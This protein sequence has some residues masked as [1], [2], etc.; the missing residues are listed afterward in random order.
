M[1]RTVVGDV[2]LEY[3]T[4]YPTYC[5]KTIAAFMF[6]EQPKLF[7]SVEQARSAVRTYRGAQG[8]QLRRQ[9][10][11]NAHFRP[12]GTQ[13]DG[14]I[15]LPDPIDN[16][17]EWKVIPVEF[18]RALTI[19]DVHIPF[20]DKNTIETALV[21]GKRARVDTIIIDGDLMDFYA[22]SFWEKDPRLRHKL[23]EEVEL[24]RVFLEHLRARFPNERIIYK[25]G[26]HEERLWR[27]AW[28]QCAEIYSILDP[29]G[30]PILSLASL[31]DTAEYGVE[32]VENKQPLKVSNSL[33]VLHGHEF[34]APF[35]N[36][37]NPARGL[38]LRTQANAICGDLHQISHHSQR[39]I[40]D[41]ISCWSMGCLCNLR[42][43]YSPLNKW[44][45]GF[46][47][48]EGGAAWGVENKKILHGKVL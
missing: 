31:M 26:N 30:N 19:C 27:Y 47:I 5:S 25:E 28:R 16:L 10:K 33:Y 17:A 48:I 22:V 7:T 36:P 2:T 32:V 20:H 14:I 43:K 24:G 21:F 39:G 1:P 13:S 15:P 44:S 11:A 35:V 46:A 29:L 9:I 41:V 18:A 3:L 8:T 6:K 37:V 45:L 23:R 34:R 42:P 38:F 40:E 12:P 4:K